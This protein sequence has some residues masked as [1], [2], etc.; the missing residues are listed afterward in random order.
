M[1]KLAT[2]LLLI[3]MPLTAETLPCAPHNEIVEH[4]ASKYDEHQVALGAETRGP[5]VEV[6]VSAGGT[7]TLIV[8]TP[9]KNA[10]V[11]AAGENWMMVD[12]PLS[13][14]QEG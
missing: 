1:L 12:W 9:D 2:I 14:D 7:W 4:L 13:D 3:G 5:I 6:F 8:T 10:C 11:V